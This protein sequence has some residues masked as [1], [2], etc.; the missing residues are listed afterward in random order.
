VKVLNN[1]S[2]ILLNLIDDLLCG[3]LRPSASSA[4]ELR[5]TQ[6]NAAIRRDRAE[7]QDYNPGA[8]RNLPA[9][10]EAGVFGTPAT[11]LPIGAISEAAI[12]TNV[13]AE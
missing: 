11:I 8:Y 13:E 10:N 4:L 2:I 3:T 12:L 1:C 5:S 9:I 7:K 6:R